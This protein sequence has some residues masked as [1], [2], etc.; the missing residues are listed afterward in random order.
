MDQK[1]LDSK[2][3]MAILHRDKTR[4]RELIALKADVNAKPLAGT[5]VSMMYFAVNGHDIKQ[6]IV[7]LLTDAGAKFEGLSASDL[8]KANKNVQSIVPGY[9]V[10]ESGQIVRDTE[11][12]ATGGSTTG[13][14][15]TALAPRP[16][17]A[18][19]PQVSKTAC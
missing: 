2:L 6:D 5:N 8:E 1:D 19:E 15:A 13:G 12:S 14:S 3:A 7:N 16:Q 17:E 4:V 10:A 11:G 9:K 18:V